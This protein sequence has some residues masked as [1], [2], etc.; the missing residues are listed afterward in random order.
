MVRLPRFARS[1]AAAPRVVVETRGDNDASRGPRVVGAY[2]RQDCHP[3]PIDG[4]AEYHREN[5]AETP[6]DSHRESSS[7]DAMS[8]TQTP[9]A[10]GSETP[11]PISASAMTPAPL[12]SCW[13]GATCAGWARAFVSVEDS[14]GG[15]RAVGFRR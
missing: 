2:R 13:S 8:A 15:R 3:P 10:R 6:T 5:V 7:G 1:S 9:K 12:P 11:G 4:A 14:L